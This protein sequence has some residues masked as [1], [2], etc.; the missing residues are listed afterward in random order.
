MLLYLSH[1]LSVAGIL[2]A[3]AIKILIFYLCKEVGLRDSKLSC[4]QDRRIHNG[5]GKTEMK[6]LKKVGF[7][8]IECRF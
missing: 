8:I 5:T 2:T 1:I 3:A 6:R 7:E 4:K